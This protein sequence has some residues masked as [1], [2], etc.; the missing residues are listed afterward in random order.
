MIIPQHRDPDGYC[1]VVADDGFVGDGADA[2]GGARIHVDVLLG[3][4]VG[5]PPVV[6]VALL[7]VRVKEPKMSYRKIKY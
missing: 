7:W 1:V 2:D 4:L 6:F 3:H 5:L